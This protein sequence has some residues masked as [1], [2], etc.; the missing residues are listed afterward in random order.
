MFLI[1]VLYSKMNTNDYEKARRNTIKML[2]KDFKE[3]QQIAEGAICSKSNEYQKFKNIEF[4]Y[5]IKFNSED[6]RSEYVQFDI[7]AQGM[8]GGQYWGIIYSPN[9]DYIENSDITIQKNGEN[10]I[11]I[12]EKIKEKWY[13]YYDDYDGKVNVQ[14]NKIVKGE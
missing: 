11:F 1:F 4:K 9:D 8:L 2:N 14:D 5:D 6:K 7:D 13:F 12:R 10:D 3:F